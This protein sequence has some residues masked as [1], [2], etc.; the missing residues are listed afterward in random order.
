[1]NLASIL[2]G[3]LALMLLYLLC[4]FILCRRGLVGEAGSKA[5]ATLLIYLVIPA[6]I[7][8]SFCTTSTPEKSIALLISIGL[9]VV[10]LLLAIVV[11]RLIFPRDAAAEFG[12]AFSNAG[13]IGVPLISAT[14]GSDVVFYVASFIALLN[15][16]QWTYGQDRMGVVTQSRLKQFACPLVVSFLLG[17]VIYFLQLPVPTILSDG[18]SAVASCNSPLAMIL[19][20]IYL[21]QTS[22][23][24]VFGTRLVWG[25][26]VVRLVLVPALTLLLLTFVPADITLRTA[27]LLVAAAPVGA[28]VSMYA[29]RAGLDHRVA[30]GSV[31]LSTLLCVGTMPLLA[32]LA[33]MLW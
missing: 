20:G 4:G 2:V 26:S 22:P 21:G 1:M 7:L 11:S 10:G 6:V 25:I 31:C 18:I 30:T 24:Y 23:R 16:L 5:F 32:I 17:L 12:A 19:L 3:Q 9:A 33:E 14:L 8:R 29:Q 27:V 13:F 15:I 28:N